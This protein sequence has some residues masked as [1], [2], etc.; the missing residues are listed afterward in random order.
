MSPPKLAAAIALLPDLAPAP[1]PSLELVRKPQ[2]KTMTASA[3]LG[4]C[5]R[6]QFEATGRARAHP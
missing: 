1:Q 4:F 5:P 3:S 2:D 6:F